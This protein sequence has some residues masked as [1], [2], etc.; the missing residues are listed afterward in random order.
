MTK[1]LNIYTNIFFAIL[2]N[3]KLKLDFELDFDFFIE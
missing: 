2:E 3:K 1:Q